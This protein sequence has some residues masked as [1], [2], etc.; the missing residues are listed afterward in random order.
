[1]SAHAC[2]RR[3]HSAARVLRIAGPLLLLLTGIAHADLPQQGAGNPSP[4]L[5]SVTAEAEEQV[6]TT[7][8]RVQVSVDLDG[9]DPAALQTSVSVTMTAVLDALVPAGAKELQT[10]GIRLNP[11]YRYD[12]GQPVLTGYQASNQV[13]FSAPTESLGTLLDLATRSGATRID[14]LT[15]LAD[16]DALA[17]ARDRV[18]QAAATEARR[19]AAVVLDSLGER[20]DHI[21][22]IRIED[23]RTAQSPLPVGSLEVMSL[24]AA[25]PAPVL[26]G[27]QTVRA[28]ISL[29]IRY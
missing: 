12:D 10:T 23:L 28:R 11:Q 7:R 13:S 5:L 6:I 3:L 9:A 8:A 16:E 21:A 25:T 26:A 20:E 19:Q 17:A 2:R 27:E 18:L 14:S 4:R 15:F 29:N 24:R 1:M 22:S